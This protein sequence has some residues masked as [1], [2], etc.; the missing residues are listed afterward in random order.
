MGV[1]GSVAESGHLVNVHAPGKS[2]PNKFRCWIIAAGR[3]VKLKKWNESPCPPAVRF[4]MA[5]KTHI[6]HNSGDNGPGHYL[7]AL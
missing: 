2:F 4:V 5:L 6:H 7:P 1:H 3:K